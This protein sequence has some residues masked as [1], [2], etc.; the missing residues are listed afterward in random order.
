MRTRI[1]SALLVLVTLCGASPCHAQTIATIAG[2][3]WV[4]PNPVAALNAPFGGITGLAVDSSGILYAS[5]SLNHVVVKITADGLS[6][7]VA[8]TGTTGFSGDGEPAT[9]AQL[10]SPTGLAFDSAGNL[11]IIDTP[12]VRK[13]A[14]DGTI[15][16]LWYSNKNR[17]A[18]HA[19][20]AI[21]VSRNVFVSSC[22]YQAEET[23]MK[24]APD[25]TASTL[26]TATACD[27]PGGSYFEGLALDATRSLV[28]ADARTNRILKLNGDGTLSTVA[29]TGVSGF[30]GDGGLAI[31]AAMS[32]PMYPTVDKA[33]N[34]YFVDGWNYRIRKISPDG[35]IS[36][37]AG[38]GVPGFSGDGGPARSASLGPP[39]NRA[40]TLP[41]SVD[42]AGNLFIADGPRIRKVTPDGII[43]T[44]AGNGLY[45]AVGDGGSAARAWL[46]TPAAV[47]VDAAGNIFIADTSNYRVRKITPDGLISTFAGNGSY[48]FFGDGEPA[49]KASLKDPGVSPSTQ[50]AT[51]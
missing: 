2:Q 26:F 47:V 29:G 33:G 34:I 32:S 51:Y 38:N 50:R 49:T 37:A 48:G 10:G 8:G 44:I 43:S 4:F 13:L 39:T 36:T 18:L 23:I 45:K 22:Q 11:L 3:T 14:P 21:D 35:T 6:T 31:Q 42:A 19:G 30:S 1:R 28:V 24:I 7:I 25:G 27:V 40:A 12:R 17:F 16:T 5:D 9:N 46:N 20:I 41:L 15:S